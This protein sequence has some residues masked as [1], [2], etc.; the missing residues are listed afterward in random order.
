MKYEL[1]DFTLYKANKIKNYCQDDLYKI[2]QFEILSVIETVMN[3]QKIN[4]FTFE[5]IL[6]NLEEID[7]YLRENNIISIDKFL[8][9][10]QISKLEDNLDNLFDFM[11][12]SLISFF[13]NK[14]VYLILLKL[15]EEFIKYNSNSKTKELLK[16]LVE[17]E[18]YITYFYSNIFK[19]YFDNNTVDLFL[20]DYYLIKTKYSDFLSEIIKIFIL[21]NLNFCNLINENNNNLIE[22]MQKFIFGMESESE[23]FDKIFECCFINKTEIDLYPK[24]WFLVIR[25]TLGDI[26]ES[27]K[28]DLIKPQ[29]KLMFK[30]WL[31]YNDLYIFFVEKI[32]DNRRLNFWKK[33]IFFM[34]KVNYEDGL[35]QLIVMETKN[36]TFLE[37][38]IVGNACYIYKYNNINYSII[39]ITVKNYSSTYTIKMIKD[40]KKCLKRFL[41]NAK[42]W[43]NE[44]DSILSELGYDLMKIDYRIFEV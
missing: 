1:I 42:Y 4:Q 35:N 15:S 18:E 29:Y 19:K 8:R 44:L 5:Q 22:I 16:K 40:K 12:I 10:I 37:F 6:F 20:S 31:I 13:K 32:K 17:S 21:S 38:G 7:K 27:K 33:Y 3:N 30:K 39:K 26:V 25:K 9:K 2:N 23:I 36:H 34:E 43:E 11:Y 24:N 28:W 41:H 14:E